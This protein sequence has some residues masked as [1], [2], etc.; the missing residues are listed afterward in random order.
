MRI[1]PNIY[2]IHISIQNC[3]LCFKC[4]IPCIVHDITCLI[5]I[6]ILYKQ[7]Q[8]IQCSINAIQ[9][10]TSN[11]QCIFI[12]FIHME[13]Q[14]NYRSPITHAFCIWIHICQCIQEIRFFRKFCINH[15]HTIFFKQSFFTR[16][17]ICTQ[18]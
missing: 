4:S 11:T 3:N 8:A 7:F 9:I 6:T 13:I 1:H 12:H 5:T 15:L 14:S 17:N 2:R 18:T 10:I 16:K